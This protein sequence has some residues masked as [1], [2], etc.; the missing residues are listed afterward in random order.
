[1]DSS[2]TVNF[3]S[4]SLVGSLAEIHDFFKI[5]LLQDNTELKK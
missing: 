2:E 5:V 4:M 1:M 3:A